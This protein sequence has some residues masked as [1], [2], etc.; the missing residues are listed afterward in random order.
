MAPRVSGVP[1]GLVSVRG[2]L[3]LALPSAAFVLLTNGYRVVD[4]YY[5][6]GVSIDAQAAI[7]SSIFV[8]LVLFAAAE[9][10]ACGVGPL[11]ARATG[12]GDDA[13][14]RRVIGTGIVML[15]LGSVVVGGL[16]AVSAGP[17]SRLL[18]L[19]GGA[20]VACEEYLRALCWTILPLFLTP[21]LDQAFLA[22]GNARVPLALHG[23][24]LVLNIVLTPLMVFDL[25]WGVA[26]AAYAANLTRGVA[27]AVGLLL[28]ARATGTGRAEL[29]WGP[30]VRRIL[31]VGWPIASGTVFYSLVYWAM[32]HT[33]ISPL[34]PEVNAALGVGFSALEGVT[35]PLFHGVALATASFVGRYLGAG[36]PDLAR[37]MVRRSLPLIC[38]L[39]GLAT[40]AFGVGGEYLTGL[41]TDDPA[42]HRAATVYAQALAWSQLAVALETLEE[43]ILSGS[44]ATR[45]IFWGSVPLNILRVPLAWVLAFPCGW[46]ALGVWWAINLTTYAKALVKGWV[47]WRGRWSTVQI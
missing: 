31:R 46:G 15:L 24:S 32:L 42:V 35:W 17:I 30:D 4:Q 33:S 3:A 47:V 29:R 26:G 16:G 19:Q 11:V 40:L 14:R 6:Q 21:L 8:L 43:G 7:G 18:G 36:R 27:T 12:A 9:L 2:L 28:L 1:E 10:V 38:T 45:A 39:G 44:G 13:E 25:G 23:V 41:F 22:M 5:V 20:A 34:G 37:Q